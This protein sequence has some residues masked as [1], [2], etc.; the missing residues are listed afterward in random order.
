MEN[1]TKAEV[2]NLT[3]ARRCGVVTAPDLQRLLWML[4]CKLR[5]VQTVSVGR[6]SLPWKTLE[7]SNGCLFVLFQIQSPSGGA[8]VLCL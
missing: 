5:Q 7:N 1:R 4:T 8:V 2:A 3:D 6:N